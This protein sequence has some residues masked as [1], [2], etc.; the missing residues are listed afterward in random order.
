MNRNDR[1]ELAKI[2]EALAKI[3]RAL[4][5]GRLE[6]DTAARYLLIARFRLRTIMRT[7]TA[8]DVIAPPV[9]WEDELPGYKQL[10]KED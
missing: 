8:S 3:H 7:V 1:A 9:W 2:S 4:V 5:T 6:A 10:M